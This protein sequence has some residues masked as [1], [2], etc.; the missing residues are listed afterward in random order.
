MFFRGIQNRKWQPTFRLSKFEL[1]IN[2][3]KA[4][5]PIIPQSVL[6]RADKVAK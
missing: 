1:G 5:R 3:C 2:L 4:D 6:Y